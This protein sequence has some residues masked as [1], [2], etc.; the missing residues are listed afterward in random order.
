MKRIMVVV[1]GFLLML[2][3]GCGQDEQHQMNEQHQRYLSDRGWDI[4]KLLGTSTVRL[5]MP[6]VR[7]RNFEAS[8]ITFFRDYLGKE[9]THYTYEWVQKDIE[10]ERLTATIYEA[11]GKIIGGY[12]VLPGWTPGT[13]RLDDKERLIHEEKIRQ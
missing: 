12:G 11:E 13:F 2:G 5:D 9:V 1:L 6:D 8:G 4:K 7:L 3:A 10:R